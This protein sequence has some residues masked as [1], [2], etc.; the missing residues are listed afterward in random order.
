MFSNL[1]QQLSLGHGRHL[2]T[3]QSDSR[4]LRTSSKRLSTNNSPLL[5]KAE[6]RKTSLFSRGNGGRDR[7][8]DSR[9]PPRRARVS[10]SFRPLASRGLLL[11]A[12]S[13]ANSHGRQWGP[14]VPVRLTMSNVRAATTCTPSARSSSSECNS[15]NFCVPAPSPSPPPRRPGTDPRCRRSAGRT[16]RMRFLTCHEVSQGSNHRSPLPPPLSPSLSIRNGNISASGK[17][18]ID[19]LHTWE[20]NYDG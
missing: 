1:L 3:V 14:S 18:M 16:R 20:S 8:N 17:T 10:F 12:T 7:L 19:A 4:K 15:R 5:G 11:F 6:K 2:A 13:E 9:R